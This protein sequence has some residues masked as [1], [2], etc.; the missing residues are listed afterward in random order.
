[1]KQFFTLILSLILLSSAVMAAETPQLSQQQLLSMQSAKAT[2]AFVV[3]DVRSAEEYAQQHISGAINISH[4]DL[5]DKLAILNQYKEA[6]VVVY[7]RS[8]R[9][10]AFAENILMSNGFNNVK[11]LTGDMNG[12]LAAEL[13]TVS[14]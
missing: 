13:P 11:H 6:T 5:A 8:G 10:A 12:W 3:L 4:T 7:C 1:M 9:R 2:S 14:Q